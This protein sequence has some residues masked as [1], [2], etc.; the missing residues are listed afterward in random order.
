MASLTALRMPLIISVRPLVFLSLRWQ[1]WCKDRLEGNFLPLLRL[2]Q[3]PSPSPRSHFDRLR[4]L[5]RWLL[6]LGW[7]ELLPCFLDVCSSPILKHRSS[8]LTDFTASHSS[9]VAKSAKTT[10][11]KAT[12]L[13]TVSFQLSAAAVQLSSMRRRSFISRLPGVSSRVIRLLLAWLLLLSKFTLAYKERRGCDLCDA[14]R[15]YLCGCYYIIRDVVE[16]TSL[17]VMSLSFVLSYVFPFYPVIPWRYPL[18]PCSLRWKA[19]QTK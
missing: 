11:S 4:P 19:C 8:W 1:C 10:L 5:Q 17:I 14:M 16:L 18:S 15:W 2:R 6:D 12:R 3:D 7:F 13:P 9:T